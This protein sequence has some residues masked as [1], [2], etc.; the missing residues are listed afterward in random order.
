MQHHA[1]S[2]SLFARESI[3]QNCYN[4]FR[5]T[6]PP[7]AFV[8]CSNSSKMHSFSITPVVLFC[9]LHHW[10]MHL[11]SGIGCPPMFPQPW[12]CLFSEGISSIIFSWRLTLVS[13]HQPSKFKP[14]LYHAVHLTRFSPASN[15]SALLHSRL[16]L[17]TYWRMCKFCV[18]YLLTLSTV[19]RTEQKLFQTSSVDELVQI[20]RNRPTVRH[21]RS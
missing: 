3:F 21:G 1:S 11:V 14:L 4:C 8:R 5:S 17:A 6:A 19:L 2:G 12:H 15:I 10:E 16:N 18:P 13:L 9:Y 7:P 20:C